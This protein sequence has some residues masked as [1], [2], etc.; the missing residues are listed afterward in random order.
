[1]R[2]AHHILAEDLAEQRELG[3]AWRGRP[4]SDLV[5]GAV[6]LAQPDRAVRSDDRL[7]EVAGL[8]LEHGKRPDPGD[9]SRVVLELL[10]HP[11]PDAVADLAPPSGEHLLDQVL[12]T[13]RLDGL[14][15]AGR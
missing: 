6:V 13:D 9:K 8:V 7:G 12:S 1:M 4:A 10:A 5:D 11:T 14:D 3:I 15:Q 2:L